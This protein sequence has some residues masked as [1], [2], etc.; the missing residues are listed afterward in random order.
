MVVVARAVL[1]SIFP[2][3]LLAMGVPVPFL[4][5]VTIWERESTDTLVKHRQ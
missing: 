3:F 4:V 5:L 1:L 2:L